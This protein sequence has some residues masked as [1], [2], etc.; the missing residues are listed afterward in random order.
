MKMIDGE[1]YKLSWHEAG[2]LFF[3][4]L[5]KNIYLQGRVH[6]RG[7]LESFGSIFGNVFHILKDQV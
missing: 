1:E 3:L 5:E 4:N 6:W 2:L 7:G